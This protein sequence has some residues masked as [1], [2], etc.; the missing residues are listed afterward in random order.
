MAFLGQE[1]LEEPTKTRVVLDD[2]HVH[3]PVLPAV[4][5]EFLKTRRS[6]WARGARPASGPANDT[7]QDRD[8]A[9]H[10]EQFSAATAI[11]LAQNEQVGE[12]TSRPLAPAS[13]AQVAFGRVV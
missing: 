1:P 2:E 12:R 13:K 5:E 6:P 9:R 10:G 3:V 8:P 7:R 11:L 4:S